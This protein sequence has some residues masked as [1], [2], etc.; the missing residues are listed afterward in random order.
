MN[1]LTAS[2]L[3]F[4]SPL[5]GIPYD[6]MRFSY[7]SSDNSDSVQ[8]RK[9][10]TRCAYLSDVVFQYVIRR[11][12][13]SFWAKYNC[14]SLGFLVISSYSIFDSLHRHIIGS[15]GCRNGDWDDPCVFLV[16]PE[17]FPGAVF[18]ETFGP[19]LVCSTH[20][21]DASANTPFSGGGVTRCINKQLIGLGCRCRRWLREKRLGTSNIWQTAFFFRAHACHSPSTW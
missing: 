9:T 21:M 2:L 3:A 1:S 17:F 6:F 7:R 4:V 10:K 20:K 14:E 13:F 16:S 5:M 15:I 12:H 18:T 11:R 8:E 19:P